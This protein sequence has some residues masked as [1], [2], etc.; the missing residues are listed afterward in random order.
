MS[1]NSSVKLSNGDGS[2]QASPGQSDAA[3][4]SERDTAPEADAPHPRKKMQQAAQDLKQ[5]QVDTD[6]H[7]ERGID[8]AENP[9]NVTPAPKSS[10]D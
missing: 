10:H 8:Q 4:P 6:Q 7:G 2:A 9:G 5:G 3:L 1:A